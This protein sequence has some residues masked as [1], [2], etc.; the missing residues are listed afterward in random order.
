MTSVSNY[1][2]NNKEKWNKRDSENIIKEFGTVTNFTCPVD[3]I[4]FA[5][6]GNSNSVYFV[7]YHTETVK[8]VGKWQTNITVLYN[9]DRCRVYDNK[10]NES[11]CEG[12]KNYLKRL[13][14]R[15]N[16]ETD[17]Y[18]NN[19]KH[20]Y[21][22]SYM[23]ISNRHRQFH[24]KCSAMDVDAWSYTTDGRP[25]IWDF[26]Y[27]SGEWSWFENK[28]IGRMDQLKIPVFKIIYSRANGSWLGIAQ[29]TDWVTIIPA[30]NA[31]K[32]MMAESIEKISYEEAVTIM[33]N[34]IAGYELF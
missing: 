21:E 34:L 18:P 30:T 25:I 33:N 1:E 28:A 27:H 11:V 24:K 9:K 2:G 7:D 19:Y 14:K 23:W 31:A 8:D 32:E 5:E 12:E 15:V 4:R 6:V 22:N 17:E 13:Y 26:K 3:F 10:K 29:E 16:I 20:T